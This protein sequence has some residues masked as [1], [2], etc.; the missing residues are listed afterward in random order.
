MECPKPVQNSI[1]YDWLHHFLP[2]WLGGTVNKLQVNGDSINEEEK[3]YKIITL[4]FSEQPLALPR[5]AINIGCH[6]SCVR[7][8][9]QVSPFKFRLNFL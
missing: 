7:C 8:Q 9:G 6:V 1:L 4:V 2:C 3:N 5:S